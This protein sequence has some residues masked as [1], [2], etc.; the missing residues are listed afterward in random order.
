MIFLISIFALF[1]FGNLCAMENNQEKWIS[2]KN[3]IN[4]LTEEERQRVFAD[5]RV[6]HKYGLLAV[7]C[8]AY[9]VSDDDARWYICNF[10]KK[11]NYISSFKNQLFLKEKI[12]SLALNQQKDELFVENFNVLKMC[13]INNIYNKNRK[14]IPLDDNDFVELFEECVDYQHIDYDNQLL[15]VQGS[16]NICAWDLQTLQPVYI[17]KK[18]LQETYKEY[19]KKNNIF[20]CP[21]TGLCIRKKLV[22]MKRNYWLSANRPVYV[23]A[24]EIFDQNNPGLNYT[25]FNN[26]SSYFDKSILNFKDLAFAKDGSIFVCHKK[27][28][29][30]VVQSTEQWFDEKPFKLITQKEDKKDT[31]EKDTLA[32]KKDSNYWCNIQ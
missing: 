27:R 25:Y 16:F 12:Y 8:A 3:V 17:D 24:V 5:Q 9:N 19:L 32:H 23:T 6:E 7:V 21:K 28:G 2:L 10:A 29:V 4:D 22:P 13:N 30:E 18:E 20:I 31:L 15:I 1:L 11:Y 14:K 26:S